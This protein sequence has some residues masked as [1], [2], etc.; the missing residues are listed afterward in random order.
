M[1]RVR[2]GAEKRKSEPAHSDLAQQREHRVPRVRQG[3]DKLLPERAHQIR[4]QEAEEDL[5]CNFRCILQ[6]GHWG[7]NEDWIGLRLFTRISG[8][9]SN[10]ISVIVAIFSKDSEISLI[11]LQNLSNESITKNLD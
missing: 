5:T 3:A 2:Q 4:T 1:P 7:G 11:S 9:R 8:F 10:L 6:F